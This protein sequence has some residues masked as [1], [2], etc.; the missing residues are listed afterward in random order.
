MPPS[1]CSLLRIVPKPSRALIVEPPALCRHPAPLVPS[2]PFFLPVPPA[3][4]SSHSSRLPS[5]TIVLV[6]GPLSHPPLSRFNLLCPYSTPGL[7]ISRRD[8]EKSTR[9]P[10]PCPVSRISPLSPN[11]SPYRATTGADFVPRTDHHLRHVPFSSDPDLLTSLQASARHSRYPYV[12]PDLYTSQVR[13]TRKS[14]HTRRAVTRSFPHP[15]AVRSCLAT[16]PP[17]S[18]I[19]SVAPIA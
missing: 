7:A 12:I 17:R 15:Y 9:A 19:R 14:T 5:K 13:C 3:I 8:S 11:P 6:H 4:P 2:L 18:G 16:S 10:T 1:R